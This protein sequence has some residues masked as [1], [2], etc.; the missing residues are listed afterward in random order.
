MFFK[1]S[2]RAWITA[3]SKIGD[4]SIPNTAGIAPLNK[5][6]LGFVSFTSTCIGFDHQFKFGNHPKVILKIRSR[7]Y[8]FKIF[9]HVE[10]K[11]LSKYVI[12]K[13][14]VKNRIFLTYYLKLYV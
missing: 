1:I 7:K 11:R 5:R 12:F 13:T 10:I 4:R 3:N 8:I 9:E 2:V 14:S 6:K